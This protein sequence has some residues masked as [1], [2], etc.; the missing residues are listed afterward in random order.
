[1]RKQGVMWL[2]A[3]AMLARALSSCSD[4]SAYYDPPPGSAEYKVYGPCKMFVT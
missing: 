3:L 4:D 1:M 2:A